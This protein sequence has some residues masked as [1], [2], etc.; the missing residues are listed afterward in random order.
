MC[1]LLEVNVIYENTYFLKL[2]MWLF[3]LQRNQP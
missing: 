1:A 3:G 2:W